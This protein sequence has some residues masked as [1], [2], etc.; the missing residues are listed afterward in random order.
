MRLHDLLSV[1]VAPI[2]IA[3]LANVTAANDLFVAPGGTYPQ[4]DAAIAAANPGDRI[5]VAPGQYEGFHVTKPLEIRGSGV[6]LTQI[7]DFD[8]PA[9]TRV[10]GI[11]AGTV[12][13]LSDMSFDPAWFQ[14]VEF[15]AQILVA[16][17]AG[18][19]VLQ[20]VR[21][22]VSPTAWHIGDGVFASNTGRLIIQ[23]CTLEGISTASFPTTAE[24]GLVAVNT[25]LEVSDTVVL[26][27][28]QGADYGEAGPAG[29][30]LDNCVAHFARVRSTGGF[31][32]GDQFFDGPGGA[33]IELVDSSLVIAG[34][35]ANLLKGAFGPTNGGPGLEV[36]ASS[37]ATIAVDVVLEGGI[38]GDGS[39]LAP[40]LSV[41]PGGT[42]TLLTRNLPA[43]V[44][45]QQQVAIGT[46]FTL[47]HTGEPNAFVLPAISGKLGPAFSV[48]GF[49]GFIHLDAVHAA[50]FPA[51]LLDG[52]GTGT[53]SVNVPLDP[54]IAGA[55]VWFQAFEFA[56][57]QFH[58]SN[59]MRLEIAL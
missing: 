2:A 13:T 39:G 32:T 38:N 41:E 30:F 1:L 43:L 20:N 15:G 26:A 8:S 50:A 49:N 33:G 4:V 12:A 29:A 40:G 27:G 44:P 58:L 51:L 48:P 56:S 21:T 19:V 28:G 54:A 34:G 11:P 47:E 14:T 24:S 3:G 52:T 35:P 46:Q 9:R 31:G 6:G 10:T 22:N 57:G 37:S 45:L 42:V 36:D 7:G 53:T 55:H 25:Y 18:T 16:D 59:P 17:N 23:G 5:F